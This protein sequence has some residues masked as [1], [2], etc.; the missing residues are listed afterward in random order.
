MKL[1]KVIGYNLETFIYTNPGTGQVEPLPYPYFSYE[2]APP[3]NYEVF[4][5]PENWAKYKDMI[6]GGGVIS[7]YLALRYQIYT[8]I[9]AICGADYAN[10]NNLSAEQKIVALIWSNIRIVNARGI[11]FYAVEC[12]SSD[13]LYTDCIKDYLDQA[14]KTRDVRY[15]NAFTIFGYTYMGKEQGLKAEN[16][17]RK[18]FL[19]TIYVERGVMFKSV[20]DIDGLGDWIQGLSGYA[21]T[22]LKPRI[23]AGEFVLPPEMPVNVF[24]DTLVGI[25]D[26]G[27]Y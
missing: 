23:I 2:D 25:L 21:V 9:E 14:Y 1:N 16:L 12:A 24:C 11:A 19:D 18:D 7:D 10:W 26:V 5:A 3:V 4:D 6:I 13:L 20:D 22:G 27:I 17:A 8:K 15:Y